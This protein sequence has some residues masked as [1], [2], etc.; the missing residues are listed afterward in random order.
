VYLIGMAP[1][2][3]G[4]LL[5]LNTSIVQLGMAVG[6]VIGGLVVE[7]F[8]LQAVGMVGAIGVAIAIVPSIISLSM[9]KQSAN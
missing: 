7:K 6:A 5:S 9:R 2:A 1:K 8:S 3:S 4:I